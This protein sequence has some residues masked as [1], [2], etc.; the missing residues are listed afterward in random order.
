MDEET[1]WTEERVKAME[2]RINETM[3]GDNW[4]EGPGR[5]EIN[6]NVVERMKPIVEQQ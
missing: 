5:R 4:N 2:K 6:I 1:S 3:E